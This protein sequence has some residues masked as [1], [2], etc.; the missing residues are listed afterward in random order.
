[1]H[2]EIKIENYLFSFRCN[3]ILRSCAT[4][5]ISH[6]WHYG[7]YKR[8]MIHTQRS[9]MM[10]WLKMTNNLLWWCGGNELYGFDRKKG[11]RIVK[12]FIPNC[13]VQTYIG[14]DISK[15]VL[16]KNYI[17]CGY[18]YIYTYLANYI[19]IFIFYFIY[20]SL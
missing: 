18:M 5:R 17:I 4:W 2:N 20:N 14:G 15:F 13:Y 7:I 9:K 1:M 8:D 16:W 6:N 11:K 12:S 10:P 3:I 19:W